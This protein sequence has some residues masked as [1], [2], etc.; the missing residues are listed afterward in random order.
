MAQFDVL[1][2]RGGALVLDCQSDLLELLET[3]FVVP[4]RREGVEAPR[5][6]QRLTPIFEIAGERYVMVT[7]LAR[8]IDRQDIEGFVTSLA[9]H[10]YEI[11]GALD[12]LVSGF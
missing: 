12:F 5:A 8:G 3:R 1:R 7:P 2:T 11:K 10:E 4:L 6:S 9:T